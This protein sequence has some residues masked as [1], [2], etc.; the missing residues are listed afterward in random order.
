MTIADSFPAGWGF[1]TTGTTLPSLDEVLA[2]AHYMTLPM[3]VRFRGVQQRESALIH[4]T[5]GWGE[6]APFVEYEDPEALF[7]FASAL[8]AA[9]LPAVPARRAEI[10]VNAT[11]PAVSPEQ[12]ASVLERYE[13]Q[14]GELKVK[15]AERGQ[16]LEEDIA[17]LR[18][19][20]ELLPEAKLKVDA[21]MGWSM[22]QA[23]QALGAFEEFD[24]LYCEQPVATI[25]ELAALR[26]WRDDRG[27]SVRIAADESVRKANDP[28]RVAREGAA[29]VLVLKAAP[30]GG[31]RR[32]REVIERAGLPAVISSALESS[33]GIATG[34]SLAASLDSL[35]YGCGLDTVSLLSEDCAAQPYRSLSGRME[36]R[37]VQ[38]DSTRL[39]QLAS[40]PER[41]SWWRAR[42]ERCY[43]LLQAS[44]QAHSA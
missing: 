20:R 39:Q 32:A 37:T 16:N 21:N 25:A 42:I 23:Q 40:V 28:L 13:G 18:R 24:L 12:V 36:V 10:A 11:L 17:R 15:V 2:S 29:D 7:W 38:P 44:I 14:I 27:L 3:A 1:I 9:Y 19:V 6:F 4:G 35:P 26:A 31:V 33:V 41:A 5:H 8:E 22:D 43:A 30:L 34:V